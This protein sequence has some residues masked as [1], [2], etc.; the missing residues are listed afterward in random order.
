MVGGYR[1]GLLAR[2]FSW[3][4]LALGLVIALRAIPWLLDV[5]D[6]GRYELVVVLVIGIVV[7]VPVLGESVGW[8]VGR[9]LAP[10]STRRAK[11]DR[12]LG[13]VAGLAGVAAIFWLLVPVASVSSGWSRDLVDGSEVADWFDRHLP[14]PPD[15]EAALAPFVGRDSFPQ[16]F[17]ALQPP[18]DATPPASSGIDEATAG[19]VAR[20]VVL[21]DG[22]A[23]RVRKSGS[24]FTVGD[25]LI[26]TN[27]HVV[28]GQSSTSIERDDG[29]RFDAT[30]VAFDPK[31]DLALLSVPGLS[32]PALTLGR[33]DRNDIGG[34][35]GHPG[36]EPLRI[37][38]FVVTRAVE[39]TGLDIYDRSTV[40]REILE[41]AAELRHGDSGSALV[42]PAGEVVGVAVSISSEQPGVAYALA[43]D[44]LRALLAV[45]PSGAVS[46]GECIN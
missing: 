17:D 29:R 26:A 35:F 14:E 1:T 22:V 19:R 4:G 42:D 40:R 5:T 24:G 37:A 27:A 32:R 23:C 45:A 16:L 7:F 30:V 8:L 31:R 6:G 18:V 12:V 20:S 33:S 3:A 44:E 28:A 13:A 36:G 38:P 46:T 39:A 43:V 9:R 11:A 21:V 2:A 15:I 10:R 41:L 34:V 25:S